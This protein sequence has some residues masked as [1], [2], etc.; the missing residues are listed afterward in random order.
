[1]NETWKRQADCDPDP[2]EV[3]DDDPARGLRKAIGICLLFWAVVAVL[4]Y[5][6][7]WNVK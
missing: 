5:A 7:C 3:T 4:V 2:Q 1:M 6:S